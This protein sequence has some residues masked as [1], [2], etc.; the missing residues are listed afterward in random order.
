MPV[1]GFIWVYMSGYAYF[2]DFETQ[3]R[4]NIILHKKIVVV[5]VVVVYH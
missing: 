3:M 4:P 2:W 1:F 5:V